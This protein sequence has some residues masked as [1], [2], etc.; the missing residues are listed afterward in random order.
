MAP[1]LNHKIDPEPVEVPV[2]ATGKPGENFFVIMTLQEGPAPEV[3]VEKGNGLDAV[4][5]VGERRVR[6][7]G[8]N[9]IIED[10]S[11]SV[12]MNRQAK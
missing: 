1:I 4:V 8:E 6:F 12:A 10:A 5:R 11:A 2:L 7:D 9:V 3:I